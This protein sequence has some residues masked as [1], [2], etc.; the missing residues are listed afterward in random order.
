MRQ[1]RSSLPPARDHEREA[2]ARADVRDE[3]DASIQHLRQAA[4]DGKPEA[5]A[6]VFAGHRIVR[7]PEV[8]EYPVVILRRNA[9]A[10]VL[11]RDALLAPLLVAAHDHLDVPER[12]ELDGGG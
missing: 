9:D 1:P 11:H 8:L 6:P 12:S 7:L 2:G 3:L 5:R 10:G 4:A